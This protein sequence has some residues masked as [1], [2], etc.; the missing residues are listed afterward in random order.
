MKPFGYL[1]GNPKR[2]KHR[3]EFATEFERNLNAAADKANGFK[4]R[5]FDRKPSDKKKGWS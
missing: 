1:F 2:R 3:R 5:K 4:V